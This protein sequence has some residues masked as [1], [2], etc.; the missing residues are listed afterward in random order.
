MDRT[1]YPFEFDEWLRATKIK[2]RDASDF[3]GDHRYRHFDSFI[4]YIDFDT[5]QSTLIPKLKEPDILARHSFYPFIRRDKKVRRFT[6][7]KLKNTLKIGQKIRPIMYASHSDACIYAFYSFMLKKRYEERIKGTGLDESVVAY[8]HIPREDGS[9]KGKSNIEFAKEVK[10]LANK[11]EKCAVLCLDISKFFDNMDHALIK[12]RWSRLIQ[13]TDLPVGHYTVFKN[14]TKFRY[15]FLYDALIKLGYGRIKNGKFAFDKK[16]KRYGIL[17]TPADFRKKIDSKSN[18]AVHKNTSKIGIPQGSP[19]SDVLANMYL[20][21]FDMS[22]LA[23]LSGFEFGYYRRYSDDILIICPED[24]A[25]SM[26]DHALAKIKEDKLVIKPSKSEVVLINNK[27]KQT[28]DITFRLTGEQQHSMSTREAFQYL[29]FDIDAVD[30]H[31]RS[32]TIAAHYRRALRRARAGN[33]DEAKNPNPKGAR[34][35]QKSNRSRWQYFINTE[36]RTGSARITRQ[37]KKAL[38]RVK[39]F[40]KQSSR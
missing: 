37:Y 17:C 31:M 40:S 9:G 35:K 1:D 36:R 2:M 5:N 8:R 4:T 27:T 24:K 29:G 13:T 30:M 38:K 18:S 7:D 3:I 33:S 16:K 26:Y 14:I 32:G 21:N 28:E 34:K 11:H 23:E 25:Q 15:V 20:E 19:I 22:I 12:E 6:F 39:S 10:E